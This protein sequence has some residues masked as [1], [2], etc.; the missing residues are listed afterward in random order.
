MPQFSTLQGQLL[1]L[2]RTDIETEAIKSIP[3]ASWQMIL[4]LAVTHRIQ[5]YLY[6]NL[7]RNGV[8]EW[9]PT[10]V[11]QK[12]LEL[13]QKETM[14][15]LRFQGELRRIADML[16]S[17]NTPVLALKGLHLIATVYPHIGTRHFKDIDF[18]I[19]VSKARQTYDLIKAMGYHV[20][21]ADEPDDALFSF[22]HN[23]QLPQMFNPQR[24]IFLEIHGQ[25]TRPLRVR[26]DTATICQRA[27]DID[28]PGHHYKVLSPEDLLLHLCVH[29][30]YADN[31]YMGLR[32]YL[33]IY[34]LLEKHQTSLDWDIVVHEAK[35]SQCHTGVYLVLKI[36]SLLFA[37]EISQQTRFK[38][39][40][41]ENIEHLLRTAFAFLWAFDK[42]SSYYDQYKKLPRDMTQQ[43]VPKK[44]NRV[45][46]DKAAL[47]E[48]YH[49]PEN[50]SWGK[51]AAIRLMDLTKNVYIRLK[52]RKIQKR[53]DHFQ[54]MLR[55]SK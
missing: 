3:E 24:K 17:Q 55:D 15:N 43:H 48:L 50:T 28:I 33:D 39:A 21:R 40:S 20:F 11:G 1:A 9:L 47:R 16:A 44:L 32:H 2:L 18:L 41:D 4:D 6:F 49:L 29:I 26:L 23:H 8:L 30:A 53:V 19:P 34:L 22:I 54:M 12:L 14:R 31:F 52:K 7:Q 5:G 25:I 38:P 35:K 36:T 46:L 13:F 42:S 45:F 51:G 37:I 10:A 27:V